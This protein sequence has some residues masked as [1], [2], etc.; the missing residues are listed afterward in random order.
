M[1][2]L[3][4]KERVETCITGRES[5]ETSLG[6]KGNVETCQGRKE[7]CRNLYGEGER[8]LKPSSCAVRGSSE[9]R[10]WQL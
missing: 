2:P 8:E 10:I 7:G 6:G 9:P 1:K 5:I 3:Y 4:R